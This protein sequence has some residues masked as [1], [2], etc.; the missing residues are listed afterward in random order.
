MAIQCC[1]SQIFL[2]SWCRHYI[3]ALFLS[4]LGEYRR[5]AILR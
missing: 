5:K 1:T 2:S 3:N 4:Y